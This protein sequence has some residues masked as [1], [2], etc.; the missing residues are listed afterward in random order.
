MVREA[1]WVRANPLAS[2]AI[3]ALALFSVRFQRQLQI[4]RVAVPAA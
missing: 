1:H 2:S 4:L 3:A